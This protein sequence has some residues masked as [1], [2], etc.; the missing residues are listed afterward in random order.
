MKF[1]LKRFFSLSYNTKDEISVSVVT[2]WV[3]KAF[4]NNATPYFAV[5]ICLWG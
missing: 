4:D 3:T 5:V 1:I 2:K